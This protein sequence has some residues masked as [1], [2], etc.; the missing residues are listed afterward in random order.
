MPVGEIKNTLY[1]LA[2][3]LVGKRCE[4]KTEK[5]ELQRILHARRA[6]GACVQRFEN[7]VL[8]ECCAV[9]YARLGNEKSPVT[10]QT[11]FRTASIAKMVT[12]LLVFRLQTQGKL[13]VQEDVSDLLKYPVRNP[14]FPDAPVTLGMLLSHTSSLMDS[15]AY[16]ASFQKPT[17]LKKLLQD[18]SSWQK[19]VPGTVFRY[20]NMAAGMVGCA[21][22][23][24]F[25]ISLEQ[26]AQQELFSP[27][28]VKATFD[29][30]TLQEKNVADSYRVL[31]S[32]MAF[33]AR[34]RMQK[35]S[36]LAMAAPEHHY[37]LAS[38][39][40]YLTATDLA[41][42]TLA[43]WNGANGF[44]SEESLRQMHTPLLGWPEPQV[45]MKHG[46]GLF[47]MERE[48][49]WGHQGFAYGAVNG[50]FFDEKG[51]GFAML[52]SGASEQRIGH[53]ALINR[54]LIRWCWGRECL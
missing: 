10:P 6:V 14:H 31:P 51:N 29:L 13:N 24:R 21:L 37:L 5:N 15:E 1:G 42:L 46:M 16:F 36:P 8:A 18:V 4:W 26:L 20:S 27:L 43:A 40:L 19:N 49:L 22:E 25:G 47:K 54:D 3:P 12:A 30:S 11:I 28:G 23:T 41:K 53:L 44:L 9:G 45:P 17:E 35:A 38:G 33:S 50:V 2:L 32:G 7:G 52:N 34:E 48:Q 39:G